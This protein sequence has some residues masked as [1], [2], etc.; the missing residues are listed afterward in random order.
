MGGAV[1]LAHGALAAGLF[2]GRAAARYVALPVFGV[3]LAIGVFG[4]AS[5]GK[6]AAGWMGLVVAAVAVVGVAG[7]LDA[8]RAVREDATS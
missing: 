2:Q 7:V 8:M 4:F 6:S 3:W 1:T 5:G